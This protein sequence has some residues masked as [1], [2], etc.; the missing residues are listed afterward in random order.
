MTFLVMVGA[1]AITLIVIALTLW[2]FGT[3]YL[4][5]GFAGWESVKDIWPMVS[6][7]LL[8]VILSWVFWWF[9]VGSTIHISI[10]VS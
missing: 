3:L 10:G 8:G 1:V 4:Q 6:V 2:F 9:V 7:C 5:I